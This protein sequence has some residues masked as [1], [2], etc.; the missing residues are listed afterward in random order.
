MK[1]KLI[2]AFLLVIGNA[3]AQI[4]KETST[5]C[6][7]SN[8]TGFVNPDMFAEGFATLTHEPSKVQ[9]SLQG[10]PLVLTSGPISIGLPFSTSDIVQTTNSG[11]RGRFNLNYI[12]GKHNFIGL[13]YQY[14]QV[15]TSHRYWQE[16]ANIRK[17]DFHEIL[18]RKHSVSLEGGFFTESENGLFFQISCNAGLAYRAVK[19]NDRPIPNSNSI[20]IV[21]L[22][23]TDEE[24]QVVPHAAVNMRV[25]FRIYGKKYDY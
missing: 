6:I 8:L 1:I 20:V 13:Q 22:F 25:G 11:I 2:V 10:G 15:N 4:N 3:Q 24:P 5:I 18:R 21:D 14:K 17:I 9:L 19:I 12:T 16:Y 23:G 7:G